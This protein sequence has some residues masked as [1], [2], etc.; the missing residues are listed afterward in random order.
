MATETQQDTNHHA[1]PQPQHAWL[2]RLVGDWSC[3]IEATMQRGQPPERHTGTERV[4]SLG[5]LW[6]VGEGTG[7][8]PGVGEAHSVM[9][10]GYDPQRE[11]FV[12]T[13]V[14][15][16][17]THLW[18]YDGELDAAERVLTLNAEGPGMAGDGS[19][20]SYRDVIEFLNDDHRTMTSYV[21]TDTGEWQRFMKA[22]YRRT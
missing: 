11:R 16:M 4:R 13:F 10:L 2:E 6:T 17:M 12:G 7:G 3:E 14:A 15:S 18:I 21:L 22:D 19:M 20:A 5:G 8:M 9:T 1:P